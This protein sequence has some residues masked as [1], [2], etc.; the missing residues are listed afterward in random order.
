MTSQNRSVQSGKA[1]RAVHSTSR[2]RPGR[3]RHLHHRTGRRPPSIF[4]PEPPQ[5]HCETRLR[6]M[7]PASL[8]KN[9]RRMGVSPPSRANS[10]SRISSRGS[11]TRLP[12][13]RNGR[14]FAGQLWLSSRRSSFGL[15]LMALSFVTRWRGL[16]PSAA[17]ASRTRA[18]WASAGSSF[19]SCGTSSPRKA[20]ARN[21]GVEFR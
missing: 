16:S 5:P 3:T 15:R 2:P 4:R 12:I 8:S 9:C 11:A 18:R 13:S 14:P 7:Q 21:G 19:G 10:A 1:A 6:C 20:L 17:R